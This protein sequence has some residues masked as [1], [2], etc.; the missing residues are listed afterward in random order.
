MPFMAN[1]IECPA[2]HA[3]VVVK[4]D[5]TRRRADVN[6]TAKL[7]QTRPVQNVLPILVTCPNPKCG[8][9]DFTVDQDALQHCAIEQG[10]FDSGFFTI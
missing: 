8:N 9:C 5:T 10:T 7:N 4:G 2:C 6:R 1:C 3:W